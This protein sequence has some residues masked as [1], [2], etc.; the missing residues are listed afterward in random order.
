MIKRFICFNI[1]LSLVGVLYSQ[2][3][4][5]AGAGIKVS[6]HGF[7]SSF[8]LSEDIIVALYSATEEGMMFAGTVVHEVTE[9][10][11]L[12]GGFEILHYNPRIEVFE[13]GIPYGILINRAW[14]LQ[15]SLL[16][17]G[18]YEVLNRVSFNVGLSADIMLPDKREGVTSDFGLSDS[19][20]STE[21]LDELK[22]SI[23]VFRNVLISY[24]YGFT[25]GP[26]KKLGLELMFSTPVTN[27]LK[28]PIQYKDESKEVNMFFT[29][30]TLKL[31]YYFRL[32][33]GN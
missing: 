25:L 5:Q 33:K 10:I 22:N 19:N 26:W 14:D 12:R 31:M 28:S 15:T 13:S 20:I 27:Q 11:Y 30:V 7:L 16:V 32:G 18:Q 24:R 23:D 29:T 4:F 6:R 8:G 9:N 2:I 21:D 1:L 17:D 3:N